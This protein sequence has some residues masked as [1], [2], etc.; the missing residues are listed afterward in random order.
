MYLNMQIMQ[1][2]PQS[3]VFLDPDA[4]VHFPLINSLDH[5]KGIDSYVWESQ[6]RTV[7]HPDDG[8]AL[9]IPA[10]TP[11]FHPVHGLW[12]TSDRNF[13]VLRA[14]MRTVLQGVTEWSCEFKIRA[15]ALVGFDLPFWFNTDASLSSTPERRICLVLND[16]GEAS[17]QYKG[18]NTGANQ[19][20]NFF[21]FV[22]NQTF[23]IRATVST[24][25]SEINMYVDDAFYGSISISSQFGMTTH[26]GYMHFTDYCQSPADDAGTGAGGDSPDG[27]GGYWIRDIKF[28]SGI[29]TP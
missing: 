2:A 12:C 23:K 7:T 18:Q 8:S 15:S 25:D 10:N 20:D 16:Q 19:Q 28:W 29:V 3:G 24:A 5:K 11:Y 22:A 17:I 21:P 26:Q 6:E 1:K 27:D 14:D 9:V 13:D 4:I